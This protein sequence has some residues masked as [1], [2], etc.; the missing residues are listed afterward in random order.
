MNELSRATLSLELG[1]YADALGMPTQ[2]LDL[3]TIRADYGFVDRLVGAGPSQVIASGAPAG[4]VTDD[5]EQTFIIARI[6]IEHGCVPA[7]ELATALIEWE[8]DMLAR[9]SLDLLGPSTKR[10]LTALAAGA[11]PSETG[12]CGT[13]NGAAMRISPVGIAFPLDD[14]GAFIDTVVQASEVTHNTRVALQGAVFVGGAVSAGIA[15]H[16][17]EDAVLLGLDLAKNLGDR[18][19]A[20]C[21]P[22]IYERSRWA[23]EYLRHFDSC[24]DILDALFNVICTSYACHESIPAVAALCSLERS[25]Q[26]ILLLAANA[27]GDTDTVGAMCGA[28]LGA[29]GDATGV[30][31]AELD[32]VVAQNAL[33]VQKTAQQLVHLRISKEK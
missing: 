6:L 16:S 22:D 14:E 29:C 24:E 23:I 10:A 19:S 12:K 21:A 30:P 27:G 33:P 18:G 13:T 28:I 4:M 11:P 25:A 32:R 31:R 5:T 7:G 26:D 3:D 2:D 17:R 8:K 9:G 1:A 15:G 20:V